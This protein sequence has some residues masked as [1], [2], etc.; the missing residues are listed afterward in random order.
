ML[1]CF[2]PAETELV[3]LISEPALGS[4]G[5]KREAIEDK[6]AERSFSCQLLQ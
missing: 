5:L 2:F 1:A 4:I 6:N 3:F